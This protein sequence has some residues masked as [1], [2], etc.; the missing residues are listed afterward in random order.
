[1]RHLLSA[2]VSLF[3]SV[4]ALAAPTGIYFFGD[5]LTDVGN[6][7]MVYTT[8]THPPGA[9]ATVPGP[10]YDPLGGNRRG[11][12]GKLYADILA[13][14]LGFSATPSETGG[15]DYAFGGARTRYQTLGSEYKGILE[16]VATFTAPPGPVDSGALYVLWGGSNN[17]QDIIT[18]KAVDVNGHPIPNLSQTIGDISSAI[19]TLYADGAREIL[20]PNVADL[21]LVPRIR[22]QLNALAAVN[23]AAAAAQGAQIRGLSM[24]YNAGLATTLGVLE[25]NLTGLEI[26]DFDIFSNLNEII[27]NAASYGFTDTTHRCYTGDDVN[28]TGGGTVCSNPDAYLWWDGIHPTT[29]LHTILGQ[30]MLAAVPEPTTLMLVALA[31][32]VTFR[33]RART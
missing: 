4:P 26:I 21:T 22:E 12:N 2:A 20:V 7:T 18:G 3:L 15:N 19:Q 10:P 32:T 24:A 25:Q 27:A 13:E 29:A 6:A 28:F 5:S 14:G 8:L 11:S 33:L 23:P 16:Q 17:L 30:R 9:P 31:L 1:M